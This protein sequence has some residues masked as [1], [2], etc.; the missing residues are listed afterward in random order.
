ML[1]SSSRSQACPGF[2][3]GYLTLS[4]ERDEAT[5][6]TLWDAESSLQAA[7]STAE[8]QQAMQSLTAFVDVTTAAP[9][10]ETVSLAGFIAPDLEAQRESLVR[11]AQKR[12]RK[13]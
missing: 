10:V 7:A 9:T 8:Y 3:A 6:V 1:D 5:S 11:H 4:P 13:R 12:W 2:R